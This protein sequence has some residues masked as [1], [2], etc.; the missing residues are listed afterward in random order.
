M[1]SGILAK[2]Q[3]ATDID[4][5]IGHAGHLLSNKHDVFTLSLHLMASQQLYA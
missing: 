3:A 4:V 2:C 1:H 5:P